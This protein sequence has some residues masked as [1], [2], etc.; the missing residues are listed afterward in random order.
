MHSHVTRGNNDLFVTTVNK[1]YG[2]KSL[3]EKATILWNRLTN[4]LKKLTSIKNL[5][6]KVKSYLQSASTYC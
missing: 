1:N 5:L 2:N 4:L 3:K 6:K